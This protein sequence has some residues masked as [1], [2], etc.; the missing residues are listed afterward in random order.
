MTGVATRGPAALVRRLGADGSLRRLWRYTMTSV[1][2]TVVSE[3]TLLIVYGAGWL[4]AA[5]AA[6]TANLAGTIPSYAMSRYWIWPE[7]DRR[8]A[9]RQAAAFWAVSL[10]SLATSTA[11]VAVAEAH[12]PGGHWAHLAVVGCAYIG[13]YAVLW[14]V[15]FAFY[16]RVLFRVRGAD[17][18]AVEEA[19]S[20][21]SAET[22]PS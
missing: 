16:Q 10:I 20:R 19:G 22:V 11:V 15:K 9:G 3:T 4:G 7:A 2:A 13:T 1:V 17:T 12:A 21:P 6:V 18:A 14:L 8:N 5:A